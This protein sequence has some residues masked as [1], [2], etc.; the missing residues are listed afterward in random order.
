MGKEVSQFEEWGREMAPEPELGI[1]AFLAR[2]I[3]ILRVCQ[4]R[5]YHLQKQLFYRLKEAVRLIR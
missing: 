4:H 5:S 3:K 1:F 2:Q